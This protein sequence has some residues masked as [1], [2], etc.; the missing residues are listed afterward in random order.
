MGCVYIR[1]DKVTGA[2][3]VIHTEIGFSLTSI[4]LDARFLSF[5]DH[6]L[7]PYFRQNDRLIRYSPRTVVA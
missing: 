2:T 7:V 3:A 1:L 6:P 4:A 5:R